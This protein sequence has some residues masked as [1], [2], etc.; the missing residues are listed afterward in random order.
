[1]IEIENSRFIFKT[2]T[3]WFSEVPFDIEGFDQ[4]S[5]NACKMNVDLKGFFKKSFTTQIIDLT[6][7][8]ETIWKKMDKSSCRYSINKAKK[9]GVN[10]ILNQEYDSFCSINS[11]FR[12]LKGLP[13][14]AISSDFMKKYGVLFLSTFN[15]KIIGGQFYLCNGKNIRW[16][17]GASR[18]LEETGQIRTLVGNA[19][20]L[21]IWEA[22]NY[23]KE[24][25]IDNFDLGGYYVGEKQDNEKENI[26]FFKK[27][28]GGELTTLYNYDKDYSK[29]YSIAKKLGIM[30]NRFIKN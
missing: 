23:A 9:D 1:M 15:E 30:Y 13:N 25:G 19:N 26:N 7:D 24:R 29:L 12:E 5:F 6:Q 21:M 11:E 4:V 22:I 2:K 18:R 3:I 17:L 14:Y 16:M 27:S 28:F 20:R 10:I 8:L